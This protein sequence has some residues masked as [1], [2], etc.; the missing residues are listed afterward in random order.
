M[1]GHSIFIELGRKFLKNNALTYG[2][3]WDLEDKTKAI[4]QLGL[5]PPLSKIFDIFR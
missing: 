3:I 1:K 4:E 2:Q 5:V